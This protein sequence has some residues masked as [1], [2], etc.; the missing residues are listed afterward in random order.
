MNLTA[1]CRGTFAVRQLRCLYSGPS[2]AHKS[3][4]ARA[5]SAGAHITVSNAALQEISQHRARLQASYV[6]EIARL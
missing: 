1:P 2:S 3:A 4:A 5:A 6:P